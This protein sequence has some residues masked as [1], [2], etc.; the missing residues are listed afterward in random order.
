MQRS[1]PPFT[2]FQ[3]DGSKNWNVRFSMGG[4]QIRKSLETDDPNEAHRRAYEL[5]G[6]AS[7]RVKNGLTANVMP[8]SAVASEFIAL[9][10]L[11]S[12][13]GERSPYHLRDWPPVI[14]RY[15]VGF[16]GDKPMTLYRLARALEVSHVELLKL[17]ALN[18][19][20]S[21]ASEPAESK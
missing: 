18:D 2:L 9:V 19:E 15:L 1:K 14:D 16:F 12:E 7:Y 17:P 3:R 10:K 6:E 4:K 20:T 11:Q 5:W 21:A 13:R 8:F